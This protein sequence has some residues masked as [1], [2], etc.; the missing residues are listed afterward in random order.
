MT[1]NPLHRKGFHSLRAGGLNW[2]SLPLRL[3]AKGNRKFWNPADI[4]FSQDAKD[5]QDF[6]DNERENALMLCA[7]FIAGEEAVTED[8]QPFMQAMASE[9][10]FGDE[11]YL[12]QFCFE[13]AKHTAVF[14]LWLDAVGVTD[15]L[16]RFVEHNPGYRAIF[17]QALPVALKT[18]ADDPSPASQVRASV[19]YNH[20]VEGT[21]AL[22]GY[23]SWNLLCTARGVLPGMQELIR[24]IGDDERRHMAWGTFTCRRHVAAD[25]TNWK[26]VTDT[27]EE[28][29]PHAL[30]Q[31]Q[32]AL[33]NSPEIP[34][35]IKPEQ[36]MAYA[37]DRATRRLNAIESAVGTDPATID[38]DYSPE[39]LED[40]FG[41]ED[42]AALTAARA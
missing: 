27:M 32:W 6:T 34:P 38:L 11:M 4:D 36:L 15:D 22:T 19:T 26:V 42:T 35:E 31:I 3:F 1:E 24:R 13:E 40:T 33:D 10:R 8:L 5:W 2:D 29:L 25:Q 23:H 18:L 16:H 39:Q 30:T 41:A 28:L 20:V 14:R 17:Y 12:T 37:G 7:Q 9:G 21:L